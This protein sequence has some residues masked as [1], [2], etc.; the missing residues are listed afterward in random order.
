MK[1]WA[2]LLLPALLAFVAFP[3][4]LPA[5][6]SS[7]PVLGTWTLNVAKSTYKGLPAPQSE[8]RT[9]DTTAEGMDHLIIH[10]VA[11]DGTTSTE[12]TTFKTDGKPYAFS[13][14][15]ALDSLDATRVNDRSGHGNL[16]LHGKRVGRYTLAVSKDGK[17]LT[18][19]LTLQISGKTA[20]AVRVFDR[21]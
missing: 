19:T 15:P 11:A 21:Q 7:D 18:D 3:E 16:M 20:R 5:Q 14:N 4:L 13:G 10:R 6:S 12:E 8:T 1:S 17:K 9:Y 2:K